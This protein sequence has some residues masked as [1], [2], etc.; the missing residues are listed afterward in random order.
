LIV[1]LAVGLFAQVASAESVT[2]SYTYPGQLYIP[3]PPSFQ[4]VLDYPS[5]S[6][7]YHAS[8]INLSTGADACDSM[9]LAGTRVKFAVAPGTRQD[10]VWNGTGNGIG[11]PYGFFYSDAQ[12]PFP[13]TTLTPGDGHN[14]CS[15]DNWYAYECSSSGCFNQYATFSVAPPTHTIQTGNGFS[16][17]APSADGSVTCTAVTPGE[18]QVTFNINATYGHFW[19]GYND[20]G[21]HIGTPQ[22]YYEELLNASNQTWTKT[23]TAQQVSCP[24]SIIPS[25]SN[26]ANGNNSNNSGGS[27]P[28]T[29]AVDQSACVVGTAT[30]ISMTSNNPDGLPIRYGIDWNADMSINGCPLPAIC[31]REPRRAFREPMPSPARKR[32][33]SWPKIT[34]ARNP[35]GRRSLSIAHNL[36]HRALTASI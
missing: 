12:Y 29:P 18:Q 17:D 5:I 35:A 20:G 28:S 4:P 1:V 10:V 8:A 7:Q 2:F 19:W 11:T 34:R 9:V 36:P 22:C 15:Q 32:S 25:P 33:K 27:G 16:C 23:I 31:L 13:N 14:V 3:P 26:T 21:R 24:I 6:V 30:T